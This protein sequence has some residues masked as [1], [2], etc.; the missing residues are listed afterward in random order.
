MTYQLTIRELSR[1]LKTASLAMGGKHDAVLLNVRDGELRLVAS[2]AHWIVEWSCKLVGPDAR[3]AVN[4]QSLRAMLPAMA[5]FVESGYEESRIAIGDAFVRLD[6]TLGS[7]EMRTTP[8]GDLPYA[9]KYVKLMRPAKYPPPTVWW[10][11]STIYM[12]KVG[13]IFRVASDGVA[14][15]LF[16]TGGERDPVHITS[17]EAPNLR[18]TLM[19]VAVAGR[20]DFKV[21]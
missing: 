17:D 7:I 2:D 6:H 4:G 10:A 19:P 16:R 5:A 14:N 13:E 1:G 18:V 12:E 8:V 21:P 20:T 9:E 11:G 3:V 15:L